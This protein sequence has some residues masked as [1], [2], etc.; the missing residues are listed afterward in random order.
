MEDYN[1]R[2]YRMEDYLIN[3]C[4]DAFKKLVFSKHIK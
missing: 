4:D 3:N 1:Y 2:D